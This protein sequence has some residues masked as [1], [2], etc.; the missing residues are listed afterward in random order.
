MP[1]HGRRL[2]SSCCMPLLLLPACT[3]QYALEV[4]PQA[5]K[6]RALHHHDGGA[7]WGTI[8]RSTFF[9]QFRALG[10]GKRRLDPALTLARQTVGW[11]CGGTGKKTAQQKSAKPNTDPSP[12]F[13]DVG[14]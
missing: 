8:Q 10:K 4:V 11:G 2:L 12:Q 3:L 13:R 6:Y 9:R 14:L 5:T 7:Q 1:W